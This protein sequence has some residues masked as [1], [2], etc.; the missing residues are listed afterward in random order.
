MSTKTSIS[1]LV[2][3][4]V[5]LMI[6]EEQEDLSACSERE[7]E[8]EISYAALLSDLREHGKI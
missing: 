5:R 3:E 7:A 8:A 6:S 4:A 2:D 1:D